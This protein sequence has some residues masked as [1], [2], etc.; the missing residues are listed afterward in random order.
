MQFDYLDVYY[1]STY[2]YLMMI[3]NTAPV[4]FE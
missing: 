3:C 2:D 4:H 1:V